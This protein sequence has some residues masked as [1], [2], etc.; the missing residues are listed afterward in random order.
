MHHGAAIVK[1]NDTYFTTHLLEVYMNKAFILSIALFAPISYA[2]QSTETVASDPKTYV[3]EIKA[4]LNKPRWSG[5]KTLGTGV[6]VGA[7]AGLFCNAIERMGCPWFLSWILG[8]V[9]RRTLLNAI[10]QDLENSGLSVDEAMLHDSAWVSDWVAYLIAKCTSSQPIILNPAE[11]PVRV[12]YTVY[13]Y[14]SH[15]F[16]S[17]D[18]SHVPASNI[19]DLP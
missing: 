13:E 3:L 19:S 12:N 15:S 5:L 7:T 10:T 4:D 9:G 14:P 18:F 1:Y 2:Q 11:R 17:V 16:P 8:K 6:T